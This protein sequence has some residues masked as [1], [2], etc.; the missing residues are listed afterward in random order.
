MDAT[1]PKHLD[2]KL[3]RA[4]FNALTRD[5]VEATQVPTKD[6]LNAAGLNP[7]DID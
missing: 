4:K 7:S 5:L 2:I 3:T 1:G 6:A